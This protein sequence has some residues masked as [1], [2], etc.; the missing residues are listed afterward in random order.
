METHK[1]LDLEWSRQNFLE[2][3]STKSAH[4]FLQ[5]LLRNAGAGKIS[6]DELRQGMEEIKL[7]QRRGKK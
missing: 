4:W 2:K 5:N 1:H 3:P 6:V 7:W